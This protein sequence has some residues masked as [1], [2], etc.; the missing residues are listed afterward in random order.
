MA[1]TESI[2]QIVSVFREETP[3]VSLAWPRAPAVIVDDS[4]V[5]VVFGLLQIV[6]QI[7]DVKAG[8]GRVD[9]VEHTVL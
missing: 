2:F 3:P 1:N 7:Q 6:R 9:G 4:V 5:N 8:L